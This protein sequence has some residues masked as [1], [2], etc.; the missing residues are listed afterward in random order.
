VDSACLRLWRGLCLEQEKLEAMKMLENAAESPPQ[1]PV[2]YP[3]VC[4]GRF[5]GRRLPKVTFAFSQTPSHFL[6]RLATNTS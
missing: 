5:V 3:G 6:F 1:R 4:P 2:H